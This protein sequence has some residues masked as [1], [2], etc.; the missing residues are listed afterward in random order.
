MTNDIKICTKNPTHNWMAD[1]EYC[2]YCNHTQ[3]E[4]IEHLN[5]AD[6]YIDRSV[7]YGDDGS[8]ENN[9]CKTLY[10]ISD[11]EFVKIG[12]A[13][14][15]KERLKTLQTGNPRR[16]KLIASFKNLGRTEW[17]THLRLR[18]KNV[19]V[20]GEWFKHTQIIDNLIK[21]LEE[22]HG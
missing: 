22:K 6:K 9:P 12:I 10:F 20:K 7:F 13:Y 11:G 15:A 4:R 3:E 14:N 21:E 2:P 17:E 16:L 18:F 8:K 1:I 19:H 5:M